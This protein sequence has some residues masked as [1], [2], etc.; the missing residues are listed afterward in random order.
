M[1]VFLIYQKILIALEMKAIVMGFTIA[2]ADVANMLYYNFDSRMH[3][4]NFAI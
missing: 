4:K 1:S 2:V 3:T